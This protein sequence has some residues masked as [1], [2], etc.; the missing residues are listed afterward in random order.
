MPKLSK[1]DRKLI[2]YGNEK[3]TIPVFIPDKRYRALK[4]L[5]LQL[6][7]PLNQLVRDIIEDVHGKELDAIEETIDDPSGM[8][9]S[10]TSGF[11]AHARLAG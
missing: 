9:E 10:T 6:G 4:M 5:S 2:V 8:H 7:K 3:Q 11:N 1:K